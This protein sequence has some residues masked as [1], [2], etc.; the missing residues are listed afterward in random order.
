VAFERIRFQDDDITN[1]IDNL[2][3]GQGALLICSHLGNAELLR[4]LAC[5][6]RTG[7][8][9]EVPVTSIIDINVTSNFNKTINELNSASGFRTINAN[10]IGPETILILQERLKNGELVV[11]A[12]DRTSANSANAKNRFLMI[13]F[14]G[15]DAPFPYG[16]FLIESLLDVPSYAV[17]ALRQKD[18]SFSSLFDLHVH[19]IPVDFHLEDGISR[20]DRVARIEEAAHFF[21]AYLEH[22]CKKYPYQW[23]NFFDFWAALV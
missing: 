10:S 4:G 5:F 22:Y 20:K 8:S 14:L 1:L 7:V 21:A 19:K 17:F 18:V 16:T 12:G 9:R 15:K 23:F 13:P 2:E 11:I 3:K 6:N